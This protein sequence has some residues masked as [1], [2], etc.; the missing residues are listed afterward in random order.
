MAARRNRNRPRRRR[1]RFGFLY[2]LLSLLII[3]GAILAGCVVFFRVNRVEVSGNSRYSA[4]EIVEASGVDIGDNLFLIN[5]PKTV[6]SITRRLPYVK[7]VAPIRRLPDVLELRITESTALAAIQLEGSWWLMDESGKLLEQ[8]GEK[9]RGSLPQVIGLTTPVPTLGSRLAGG[10]GETVK[11]ESLR[12]LLNA[13]VERDMTGHVTEFIDLSSSNAI[14]FGYDQELT[15]V[16]PL[17]GDFDKR[18]LSL[19]RTLETLGQQGERVTGTL[20]LTYGDGQARLLTTRWLPG[21]GASP[22]S[23]GGSG[24]DVVSPG[25]TP[26]E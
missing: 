14:Y 12:E 8:G 3:F 11:V 2:K 23:A 25:K 20:D 16:V 13:L 24:T 15:V 4:Q 18:I 21:S 22:G 10:E 17:T 5:S 7:T 26:A 1:G 19:Q 9:L 6:L